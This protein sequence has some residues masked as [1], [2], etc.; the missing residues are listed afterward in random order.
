METHR[1]A[2]T[3]ATILTLAAA[4]ADVYMGLAVNKR[5]YQRNAF[6][7]DFDSGE[8]NLLLRD[9]VVILAPCS[10]D[11]QLFF[12]GPSMPCPL[13]ATGF[14]AQGDVDRDGIR[15]DNQYWSVDS[16]IPALAIEPSRPDLAQLFSAPPSKLPRPLPNFRDDSVV[17]F[18]NV[19]TA[20]VRQYD[21]SRY[22]L[23][24]R[25]GSVPQ[26]ETAANLGAILFGG[27]LDVV[28]TGLDIAGSPLTVPVPVGAGAIGI[29]RMA[30]AEI[31]SVQSIRRRPDRSRG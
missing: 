18:Y 6:K 15:D 31:G 28:V 12:F 2:A 26:V 8:L 13:G 11:P 22:E 27:T 1:V 23:I 3:I 20:A 16:V 24:L 30:L 7:V 25:Y 17:T 14:V 29:R 19:S 9:G 10:V 21:Q 5:H 4:Q